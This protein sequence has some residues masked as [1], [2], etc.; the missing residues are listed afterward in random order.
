[1]RAV[2]AAGFPLFV[3]VLTLTACGGG[4]E[5]TS[6]RK[7]TPT[8][9]TTGTPTSEDPSDCMEEAGIANVEEE[10]DVWSGTDIADGAVVTVELKASAAEAKQA[11]R[12]AELVWKATAGP[13]FVHGAS[14]EGGDSGS[15]AAI[16]DCLR[17]S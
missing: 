9:A 7:T 11:A 5:A 1:M 15:V 6:E 17:A 10:S 8:E 14:T 4:S 16:A 12:D 2:L 13:Y 3:A